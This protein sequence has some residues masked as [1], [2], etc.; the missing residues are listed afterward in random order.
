V[1]YGIETDEA[2]LDERLCTRF[3]Y[4]ESFGTALNRFC[5]QA[6]AGHP[7]TVYGI[8]GQTRGFL[9]IRDTLQCVELTAGNPPPSGEYR[10]FNQFTEQFTIMQLAEIV[11]RAAR[12]LGIEVQTSPIP[13]WRRKSTITMP[14]TRNLRTSG[15]S[16]TSSPKSSSSRC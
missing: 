3:D 8:G 1:V 6:V 16:L 9:N 14:S 11:Q 5:V 4:D 12:E 10:V 2:S 15:W 7:L 13:A